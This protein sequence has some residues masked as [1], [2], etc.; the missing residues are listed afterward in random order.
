[1]RLGQRVDV[2]IVAAPSL[3]TPGSRARLQRWLAAGEPAADLSRLEFAGDDGV[4]ELVLEVLAN[5]PAP[6]AWHGVEHVLWISVGRFDAG[7]M[8]LSPTP[9]APVGDQSHTITLCGQADDDFLRGVIAHE[10]GHSWSAPI[11][12]GR[13]VSAR[14][15]HRE[16][17]ARTIAAAKFCGVD[18]AQLARE[19]SAHERL[20]D[21][22]ARHWGYPRGTTDVHRLTRAFTEEQLAV[23]E[24]AEQ[25][26]EQVEREIP[27]AP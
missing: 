14:L 11:Q 6:V 9:R 15:S 10:L 16:T 23:A 22:L 26:A 24:L 2:R 4:R 12:P 3:E 21:D 13:A 17:I 25:I 1:M 5:C 8:G 7:W 27:G 18:A 19:R 20:A